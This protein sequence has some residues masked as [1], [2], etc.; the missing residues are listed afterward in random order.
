VIGIFMS[1]IMK[2]QPLTVFGDGEQT[3]AFTYVDDVAPHV[4]RAV[5]MPNAFGRV[6]N[7]GADQPYSVNELARVVGIAFGLEPRITHL[8]ARNEVLHAFSDHARARELFGG[9]PPVTLEQGVARMAS[10][11][12]IAGSRT[13]ARFEA[14][15]LTKGLPKSWGA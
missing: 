7:I 3:R 10:W 14:I 2:G 1:Q 8:P 13:G 9:G 11:A 6:I 4:A 12:R 5:A 15:E